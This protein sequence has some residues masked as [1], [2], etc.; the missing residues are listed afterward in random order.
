MEHKEINPL[1]TGA[2]KALKTGLFER[3]ILAD[4]YVIKSSFLFYFAGQE[5]YNKGIERGYL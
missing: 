2:K 5:A 3:P 4:I 1:R